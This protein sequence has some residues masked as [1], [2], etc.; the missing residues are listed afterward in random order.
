MRRYR[1]GIDLGSNSLG[2]CA[3]ALDADGNP[4]GVLDIGVR[5]FTDGRDPKTGTSLAADRRIARQMRRRRDRYLKRRTRLMAT[6][7]RHGLMPADPTERKKLEALDPYALRAQGLDERLEPYALGRALFHLNQRRGFKSSRKTDKG[8]DDK[9]RG[10]IDSGIRRLRE[11]LAETGSWTIGDYLHRRHETRDDQGRRLPVRVRPVGKGAKAEYPFYPLRALVEEEFDRLWAKQAEYHPALLTDAAKAE[12]RNTIFHQRPLRPVDPGRCTL[13]PSDER[14]PWALP[15]AQRFRI[16][17][18]LNNLR[19]VARDQT[20]RRLT[21]A[22]R[23]KIYAKLRPAKEMTFEQM[24]R[25]LGLD[26]NFAFNLESDKRTSLKGDAV[27]RAL[28]DRSRFGSAWWTFDDGKQNA[29]VETILKADSDEELAYTAREHW[30]LSE[31]QAQAVGRMSLPDGYCRLG[32]RALAKIVPIMQD[33][34]LDEHHAAKEAG[35]EPSDFRGDGSADELPYYGVPLERHMVGATGKPSDPDP[36]RHGR[37]PNPTVHIG[38]NQLRVVVNELIA[39][40]GK[41]A[42]IVIELARDIKLSRKQKEEIEQRIKDDTDRNE[43]LRAELAS[44]GQKPSRENLQRLKLWHELPPQDRV[45][46]YT[47]ERISGEM[48]FGNEVAIDHILPFKDTLDDSLAN[49]VI[50]LRRA[51][52]DKGKRTPHEAFHAHPGYDWNAI[53]LRAEALPKNKRWRFAADAM[54]NGSGEF[55][56]RALTDTAYVAKVAKEYLGQICPSDRVWAIPGKL[57]ALLRSRWGLNG[58]LSDSNLKNRAD[59]RHHAID[60]FVVGC[61]DRA[62]LK[63]MSDAAGAARLDRALEDV[64]EPWEGF[65]RDAFRE[66]VRSTVVSLRPDHG[67]QARLHEE[68]AYGIIANPAAEDGAT[69]VYRKAF[70]DLNENEIGRIRDRELRARVQAHLDAVRSE[71]KALSRLELSAALAAFAA[72]D[73]KFRGIRHVRLIKAEDAATLIRVKDPQGREYKALMPGE[74]WCIDVFEQPDGAWT[75]IPVT[76]FQ[77]NQPAAMD[78]SLKRLRAERKLHPTARK[79]MRI[80]KG[81]Y[82]RLDHGGAER[83]MRVVRLVASSGRIYLAEHNEAGVLQKR[84]DD[85]DDPFRWAWPTIDQLRAQRAR[86]VR[87]DALGRIS[88]PGPPRPRAAAAE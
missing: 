73:P 84:H 52:H 71:N 53:L 79:V 64:P 56:A 27:G 15:L 41:P 11:A 87:I 32:R 47:G 9:E 66:R 67:R 70:A 39:S 42:E 4:N 86:V 81:D 33:Q 2:W 45:C 77:A 30:G 55:I 35:Y 78:E 25:T 19:I 74:N 26:S 8:S 37:F 38:L 59:H 69:V 21:K 88:D 16:L 44:L 24:R 31:D 48:L 80:H 54:R 75:G 82:I 43:R 3:L 76:V 65:D 6:L 34:G 63:R 22:E 1:L 49:K 46:V 72:E 29:I 40:Y 57:T 14:A 10:K 85:K 62:L 23:D 83:I 5:L 13:D 58:I 36:K 68:T 17:K 28:A 61:T 60:A 51:N 12:I 20:T 7:V 18:E 50:C